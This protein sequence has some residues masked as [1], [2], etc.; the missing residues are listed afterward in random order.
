MSKKRKCYNE[1]CEN[2]THGKLC[3]PCDIK[4]RGENRIT[5]RRKY[6]R[7]QTTKAKYGVDESGFEVL[8]LAFEGKCGICKI[9]LKQPEPRKGQSSNVVAIDHDHKTGNLR[10]LLC[11]GCNKGLGYFQD[12]VER[13]KAAILWLGYSD[14]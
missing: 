3:K 9:P 8:W 7:F 14:A 13:L 6:V 11:N 5:D 10:G 12:D 1:G 2:I 4:R